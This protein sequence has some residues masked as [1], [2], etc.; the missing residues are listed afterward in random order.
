MVR[1]DLGSSGV[2][3][4][5]DTESGFRDV[6]FITSSYGLGEFARPGGGE[7]GR[8]LRAQADAGE[9]PAGDRA[10]RP[11]LQAPKDGV[12]KSD[13]AGKS[14]RVVDVP[15]AERS[16]FSLNDTEVLELARYAVA[17]EKHYGRPMDIEWAKDGVDGRIYVLQARPET[18]KS[19]TRDVEERFALKGSSRV[20]VSGRAIGHKIGSGTVRIIPDASQMAGSR[21][22]TCWLRT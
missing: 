10:P 18:V 8:V 19:R 6:V 14:T 16:V 1:S 11:G 7:P 12:R 3:F 13:K 20:L 17:I 2:M 15:E 21:R 22:A 9:G 5:L 4:T